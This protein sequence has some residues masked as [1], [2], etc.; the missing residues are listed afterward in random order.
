MP[1]DSNDDRPDDVEG[2]V[3]GRHDHD[4]RRRRVAALIGRLIARDWIRTLA[5][6]E[7]FERDEPVVRP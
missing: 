5:A 3:P 1:G 6:G 4:Q 2:G 7:A